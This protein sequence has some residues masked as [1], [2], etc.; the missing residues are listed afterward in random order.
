MPLSAATECAARIEQEL[1]R[2]SSPFSLHFSHAY[3]TGLCFYSLLWLEAADHASVLAGLAPAWQ[4]VLD[5]TTA[6][7]GTFDHH[8]GIGTIRGDRYRDLPD[9]MVHSALKGALD[10][11]GYLLARLLDDADGR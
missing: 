6:G 9:R 1:A 7:G 8:H 4:Q 10:P 5:I 3:E 2:I 11:K